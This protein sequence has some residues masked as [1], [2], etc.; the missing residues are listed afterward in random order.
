[1]LNSWFG[2]WLA[3]SVIG[4]GLAVTSCGGDGT[5]PD[6]DRAFVIVESA[7]LMNGQNREHIGMDLRNKGGP[8]SWK[9]VAFGPNAAGSPRLHETDPSAVPAGWFETLAVSVP[10]PEGSPF[11]YVEKIIIYSRGDEN[12]DWRKT[13]QHDF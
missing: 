1:M 12:T 4:A 7:G 5:G 6:S 13:G 2:K 8:G 3:L 9:M 10:T 11:P